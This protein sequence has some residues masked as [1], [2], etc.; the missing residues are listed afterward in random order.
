MTAGFVI[1]NENGWY[2]AAKVSPNSYVQ[3]LEHAKIYPTREAAEVDLCPDNE[4]IVP[5]EVFL[6]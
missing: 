6:R 4:R 1:I 3:K 2:V 5:L